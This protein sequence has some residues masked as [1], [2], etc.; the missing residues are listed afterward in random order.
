MNKISLEIVDPFRLVPTSKR[1]V[2]SNA[3][4]RG[5]LKWFRQ[6]ACIL[7]SFTIMLHPLDFLISGAVKSS[8][9]DRV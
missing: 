8:Q 1:K 6:Q 3:Y 9:P 7:F 5:F 4:Q 2:D